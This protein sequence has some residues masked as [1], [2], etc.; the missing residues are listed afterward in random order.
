MMRKLLL[1][2]TFILAISDLSELLSGK[3]AV[4]FRRYNF[5]FFQSRQSRFA[6]PLT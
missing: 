1:T 4:F 5:F 6:L 3:Q 2:P